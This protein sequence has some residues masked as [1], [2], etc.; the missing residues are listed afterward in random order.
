MILRQKK[1]ECLDMCTAVDND[2]A[3]VQKSAISVTSVISC[4]HYCFW[5]EEVLQKLFLFFSL[6]KWFWNKLTTYICNDFGGDRSTVVRAFLS[7]SPHVSFILTS[8]SPDFDVFSPQQRVFVI[9]NFMRML[10][11]NVSLNVF[12]SDAV[13]WWAAIFRTQGPKLSASKTS[14]DTSNDQCAGAKS[15]EIWHVPEISVAPL[16]PQKSRRISPILQR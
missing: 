3:L 4:G 6:Q 12:K 13:F 15:I 14:S 9:T 10:S 1:S 16:Q 2:P 5:N 11:G 7:H 8:S